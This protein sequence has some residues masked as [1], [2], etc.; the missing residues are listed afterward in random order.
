MRRLRFA[1]CLLALLVGSALGPDAR[2][3]SEA[4]RAEGAMAKGAAAL[5]S[6]RFEEAA[7]SFREAA[8]LYGEES[9]LAAR[10]SA[11]LRLAQAQQSLGDYRDAAR[12]LEEAL[13]LAE[14]RGDKA[15]LAALLGA[16]GNVRIAIG[17]AAEAGRAL[18][19]AIAL[20]R[21]LGDAGLAA[22]T[23]NNL[24][25][26]RTSQGD[27]QGALRAYE[28]SAA[29][30]TRIGSASLAARAQA[31]AARA[32]L[33]GGDAP[34]ARALADAAYLQATALPPSH[35]QADLLIH[36]AR[37][38]SRLGEAMPSER[39]ALRLRSHQLLREAERTAVG[40]GD[41]RASSFALGYLGALYEE[42]ARHAEALELTQRA[43]FQAQQ[44][45]APD[46]LYLWHWQAGR[47]LRKLG[48]E[49]RAIDAYG[50]AVKVLEGLRHQLAVVYGGS[51]ASF[52]ESAG[53]AYF[54]LVDLLL[55][56]A[57]AT[58][59]RE[60]AQA[61]LVRARNTVE[62]LKK[63]E[64][65]DYFRDEC[66]DALQARIR[67]PWELSRSA[68]VVYPILLPDRI[69]LLLSFGAAEIERR[70][71]P[72]GRDELAR[73]LRRFRELLEK[74]TTNQYRPA[75]QKLYDWLIRPFA[76]EL[77]ERGVD[78]LVFVPWGPLRTV[79]M[80]ALHDG[81]RFVI[82]E[83]AV[84]ITPGI[85]L[86]DPRRLD[87]SGIKL[88]LGGLSE[89]VQ[90]FPALEHVPQE[91]ASVKA[92]H[93]GRVLLDEAFLLDR[94]RSTLADEELSVVHF[95][96]HGE[97]S[98]DA[99]ESFLLAH[100][101]RLTLERLAEDVGLFRFRDTPLELL[102]LSACETA[103]GDERA[104]LGLSGVA[105]KAGAR[106]A[107]A[108]LWKVNDEAAATLVVD[109]YAEL[110]DPEVSRAEALRRAQ[111]KLLET[112]PYD[113]PGYWSAFLLIGSWL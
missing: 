29:L 78:T 99:D 113:H 4:S 79:P 58:R 101:G 46:S 97:F 81:E 3:G 37:T 65:R 67:N 93:G 70:S 16:L 31:N 108:T 73:E 13:P 39:S 49:A 91:L 92:L 94:V 110:R 59:D 10:V 109:F 42:E 18:E 26:H 95:A 72:V 98:G 40:I 104:A 24:G 6:G 102:T 1:G 27:A 103:Q 52:E 50:E 88:L 106:S 53:N 83:F 63:A 77:R 41:A 87:R 33:A 96:T 5:E 111:R 48:D 84:A 55:R 80:A 22:A 60:A 34:R 74:R 17:P 56:R 57:R 100:D 66:V 36:L 9:H 71:V 44:V 43:I 45:E 38:C 35:D 11:L 69:E 61:L 7:A 85:E 28:E 105:I 89:P 47:L 76:S 64:L 112:S 62:L 107:L 15:R 12:S 8:D 21:E 82:E 54:E 75:A 20:A 2:A 68:V 23:T 51:R 32:A 25:N 86:T 90:G 14:R 19:R 30:A